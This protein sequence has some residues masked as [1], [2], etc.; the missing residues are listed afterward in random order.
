MLKNTVLNAQRQDVN[1]LFAARTLRMFGAGIMSVVLVLFLVATGFTPAATGFLITGGLAASALL[2]LRIT[3]MADRIG[4][5]R[6]LLISLSPAVV[7]AVVLAVVHNSTAVGCAIVLGFVPPASKEVGPFQALEQAALASHATG[8]ER[9]RLFAL[10]NMAGM[11]AAALGALAAGGISLLDHAPRHA[12]APGF[13][14]ILLVYMAT[15]VLET[16]AYLFVSPGIEPTQGESHGRSAVGRDGLSS[17][18]NTVMIL[19]VLFAM[20]SFGGGLVLQSYISY[21]FHLKY[22]ASIPVV[23]SILFGANLLAGFSALGAAAI[24][25]RIGLVNTMVF[26]H[27]PSNV[28]LMLIPLMPNLPLAIVV[29][30]LRFSISQMDVPTRQSFLMAAVKPEER[31]AAAGITGVARTAG[32]AAAPSLAG[33]LLAAYG[34]AAVPFLVAGTIKITYDLL[35]LGRFGRTQ[36]I[37]R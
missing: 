5:R 6:A 13:H 33:M 26:T 1:L 20:D 32:A 4:R 35:L 22:G 18:R 3:T 10:Y 8:T 25:K 24:A 28:L 7:S 23:G 29:L 11:L 19:S 17:S 12:V 14:P 27:I 37:E 30:L 21:W 2:T 16:A 15:V 9:T 31:S 36:T 34:P